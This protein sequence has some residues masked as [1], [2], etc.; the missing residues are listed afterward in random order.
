MVARTDVVLARPEERRDSLL[1]RALIGN[2]LFSV[3]SG[4]VMIAGSG[5]ISEFTGL[6]PGWLTA[7]IGA[8]VLLWALDVALIV[9]ADELRPSRV[10]MVIGGDLAWV[11][12]SY[13]VLMLGILDSTTAGVWTIGILAEIAGVFAVV[14]YIGLRRIRA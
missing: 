3:A 8:G 10:W 13:A 5:R 11:V 9:R 1:R 14:Q 4:V 6:T 2:A 12:A 7:A